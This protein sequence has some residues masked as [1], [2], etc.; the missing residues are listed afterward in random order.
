[1]DRLVFFTRI[2]SFIFGCG[3]LVFFFIAAKNHGDWF[4]LLP[5]ICLGICF[6]AMA[7]YPRNF[8]ED[9]PNNS[10]DKG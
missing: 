2:F 7:F 3:L 5:G 6:F 10:Q 4:I 9:T 8:P 1:M